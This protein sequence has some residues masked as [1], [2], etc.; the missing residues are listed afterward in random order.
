[1]G[2]TQGQSQWFH[3]ETDSIPLL[4]QPCIGDGLGCGCLLV[5]QQNHKY[6]S[7]V[8]H[9]NKQT[10]SILGNLS[11]LELPQSTNFTI[12]SAVWLQREI[13]DTCNG[14]LQQVFN[15]IMSIQ[16]ANQI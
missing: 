10:I 7:K 5:A 2:V 11:I 15:T 1:M 14:L 3:I 13:E 12:F 16:L 6:C 4:Q 9:C 8:Y